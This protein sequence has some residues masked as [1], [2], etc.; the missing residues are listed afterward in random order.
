MAGHDLKTIRRR[1][2][3]GVTGPAGGG[4]T[5]WIFTRYALRKAGARA[6]RLTPD[7]PQPPAPLDGLVIGGGDDINPRRYGQ[8]PLMTIRIDH[9]RDDFEWQMLEQA[10]REQ[11]PVMGICRGAQLINVVFGGTLHQHLMDVIEDLV[12][13][14]TVLPR[15][16][17][18]IEPD[19][20]LAG[21]LNLTRLRVN[22]LHHQGVDR[23]AEGFRVAA[24]DRYGIVQAIEC[25]DRPFMLG[26]QWH[27]EYLPQSRSQQRLFAALAAAAGRRAG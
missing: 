23:T 12:L 15:K 3:I 7:N 22:S 1:P 10:D 20:R 8:T 5:A 24:R 4:R 11:L 27:P 18:D 25:T 6:C 13:R 2:L 26:V 19:S 16:D 9:Q 21:I 14:R 17:I